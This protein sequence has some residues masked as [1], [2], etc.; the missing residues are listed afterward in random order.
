MTR[1]LWFL[2]KALAASALTQLALRT[3]AGRDWQARVMG[4]TS[5]NGSGSYA[6]ATY[7]GV[8]ANGTAPNASDT[9][10]TGEISSGTL[11]RAQGVYAHTNGTG[12][13]TVTKTLTSDQTVTLQKAALFTASSG[14]TM[15]FESL[16]NAAASMVS[17]DQI[18][19]TVTVTL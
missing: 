18:Q 16:L 5:S 6:P 9:T 15:A 14:G 11:A 10:L 17:G 19:L 12:S 3:N 7:F 13:Y 1:L 8:T 4:D 2:T